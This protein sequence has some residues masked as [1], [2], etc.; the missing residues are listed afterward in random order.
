MKSANLHKWEAEDVTTIKG[1]LEKL[2]F[3]KETN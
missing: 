2:R 1:A 3:L